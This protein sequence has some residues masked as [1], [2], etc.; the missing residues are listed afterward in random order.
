MTPPLGVAYLAAYLR[1]CGCPVQVIDAVGE[2]PEQTVPYIKNTF[3]RGL[4]FS[5]IISR[6]HKD[7]VLIGISNLFSFAYPAVRDLSIQVKKHFPHAKIVLGGKHPS[8]MWKEILEEVKEV[9]FVVIGDDGEEPLAC[10]V[11][12]LNKEITARELSGIAF[13]DAAGRAV[14]T[15]LAERLKNLN[16]GSL[17]YPA[18]DLLPMETYIKVQE[19]HGFSN[20]RW[21]SIIS[22]R[23]CPYGCTFCASR[24]TRWVQRTPQDVVDEMEYC[25][26]QWGIEEFHFE[27]DNMTI[28]H[29]RLMEICDEMIKRKLKV[30]WQTPNGIRAS[31][32]NTDMLRKMKESGCVHITLAPET[33]SQ[34]VIDE[35]IQKGRDFSFGQ[36]EDCG[37]QA[38]HLG[39]KVAAYFI[40]GLPGETEEDV[41]QTIRYARRLARA[42]VD[43]VAFSL[44]IPLPGTPL[45]D[46]S[47][48]LVKDLDWLDLLSIGDLSKAVSFNENISSARLHRLRTKAYL[49]FYF[50]RMLY[51]PV[52][53]MKTFVNVFRG[54]ETTKSERVLR[55]FL[56]RY[57][58][59]RKKSGVPAVQIA[60]DLNA[61]PFDTAATIKVLLRKE[62]H[63]AYKESFVKTLKL[64]KSAIY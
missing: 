38:H 18:R 14:N 62:P 45:W 11:K 21:T 26:R 46:V 63:Y 2:K 31:R 34:R 48:H 16:H 51:H 64:L 9:D 15:R 19:S 6:I 32:M 49:S 12:Y 55:T 8:A 41:A 7:S 50:T 35:I 56:K 58:L 28:N 61:Y 20:G 60:N 36:L 30:K 37:R 24:K 1:Q 27:D 40:I 39:M 57:V 33:G 5:E 42:G 4:C 54:F 53:F 52:S 10:L 17:P 3:L 47:K 43:E 59:N 25:I 23:G 44:F 13:R 29:G 22:S